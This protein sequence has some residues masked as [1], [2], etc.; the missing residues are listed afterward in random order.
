MLTTPSQCSPGH[1][2][3]PLPCHCVVTRS[4]KVL[5]Q[6]CFPHTAPQCVLE[7]FLPMG[8]S[9]HFPLLNITR[10]L[11]FPVYSHPPAVTSHCSQFVHLWV[12][13][14]VQVILGD[15][16]LE[17]AQC[18]ALVSGF[19]ICATNHSPLSPGISASFQPASPSSYL[20]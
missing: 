1:H 8:Q 7:L 11:L 3:P 16:K 10:F 20:T 5:L 4:S 17:G 18:R 15:I 12:S 6:G 9:G 14:M 19:Q 13:P 2:W